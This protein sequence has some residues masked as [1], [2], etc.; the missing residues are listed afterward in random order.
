MAGRKRAWQTKREMPCC[1]NTVN[2]SLSVFKG[3][4]VSCRGCKWQA[5][6]PQGNH[7]WKSLVHCTSESSKSSAGTRA[8]EASM[9]HM[10][11]K[12]RGWKLSYMV[13][14]HDKSRGNL[15]HLPFQLPWRLIGKREWRNH[16]PDIVTCILGSVFS[17]PMEEGLGSWCIILKSLFS[18]LFLSHITDFLGFRIAFLSALICFPSLSLSYG[19]F[20]FLIGAFT[21]PQK[22]EG[23]LAN[24]VFF[25]DCR[26][27]IV[28][29]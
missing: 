27:V 20:L 4:Q 13:S 28:L 2:L 18:W 23:I 25:T 9:V 19:A 10:H 12:A 1:E 21:L 16:L 29:I 14:Q 3:E 7:V 17:G 5:P 15:A 24:I 8:K 26:N 22:L 6:I 11:S